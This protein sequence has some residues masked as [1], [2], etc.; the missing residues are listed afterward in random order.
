MKEAEAN[1]GVNYRTLEELF[2]IAS[3]RTETY[4]IPVNVLV[5]YNEQIRD[6]LA[7][8]TSKKL[9]IKQA[10][11]GFHHIP[12]IVEANVENTQQVWNVLQAGSNAR[13]VGSNNA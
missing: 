3:E 10:S 1:R 2:K 9:E 5:V 11:D 6:L 8:E 13:A 12:G 7:I 4:N